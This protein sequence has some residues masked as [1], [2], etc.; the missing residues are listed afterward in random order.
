M[1]NKK[2]DNHLLQAAMA[3]YEAQHAEALS[4]L[5]IYLNTKEGVP[6][7]S[8]FLDEIKKWTSVLTE[9]DDNLAT[10]QKHFGK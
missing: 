6:D 7:H 3:Y 10:L 2:F 5:K 1:S 8:G 9:A 4:M